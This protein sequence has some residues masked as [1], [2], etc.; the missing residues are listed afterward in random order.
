MNKKA[1]FI[2]KKNIVLPVFKQQKQK[3][4][5]CAWSDLRS[6]WNI[7]IYEEL[8]INTSMDYT[9]NTVNFI[10]LATYK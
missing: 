5:R 2:Q 3:L 1:R 10:V 7:Y 6:V 9:R 8:I 4:M